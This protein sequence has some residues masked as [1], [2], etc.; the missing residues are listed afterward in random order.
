M[1]KKY[2]EGIISEA[3]GGYYKNGGDPR[4]AYV[5]ENIKPE[6]KDGKTTFAVK[7]F[8]RQTGHKGK[9]APQRGHISI[10]MQEAKLSPVVLSIPKA[11]EKK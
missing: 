1:K 5:F 10:W 9:S 2:E 7:A 6:F 8:L 11:E 4:G 3:K